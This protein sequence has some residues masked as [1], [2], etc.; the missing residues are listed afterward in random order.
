MQTDQKSLKTLLAEIF[1]GE[2]QW[3]RQY[4]DRHGETQEYEVDSS[5]VVSQLMHSDSDEFDY[6]TK[7]NPDYQSIVAAHVD[8]YGGEDK[9]SEY[10]SVWKFTKDS[11]EVLVKFEGYYQSHY[12]T[13][14][15]DWNFVKTAQKMVT[16][17]VNE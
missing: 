4:T 9:G 8:N 17:Y 5:E 15:Q 11:E 10:W 13:D 6:L 14:F 2:L 16:V 1:N 12:G 7:I 3:K